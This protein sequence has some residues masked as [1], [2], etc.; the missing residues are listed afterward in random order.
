MIERG[1]Y[2]SFANCGLPYHVGDVIPDESELLLSSPEKF[3]ERF[4][5]DVRV[6]HEVV[7]IDRESRSVRVRAEGEVYEEPYDALVLATGASPFR[8]PIPGLE[9]PGI[10]TL[11]TVPE[12]RQLRAWIDAHEAKRAV[13]IGAGFVG[14]E[15]AENLV[16]RGLAVSVLELTPQVMPP[17]DPEMAQPVAKHLREHGVR[18]VL[19]E[20]LAKV[21]RDDA[22]LRVYTTDDRELAADLVIL[23]MGVRPNSE[24]ARDADLEVGPTGGIVVDEQMRTADPAIWSVGDVVQTQCAVMDRSL[25]LP[26]AGPANRQGRVAA[27]SI[28][29]R[30]VAFRGVQGTSVCG[31][32]DMTVASTGV[33]EKTLRKLGCED[34]H[35][36]YLHPGDHV[37]YYPGASA[38][39]MKLLFD[40]D[41]RVLGAQAVGQAGVEKRIDVI[42]MAIQ[43]G[44]KVY[45]LEEAELCYAPQFGA[46]KDPVN[47]AG[48]IA[49]NELRGDLPQAR[50]RDLDLEKVT[51]IDVREAAE[52]VDGHVDG[53]ISIPLSEL[54]DRLDDVPTGREV[55]LYCKSGKRSYDAT[56]A[57]LQRGYL[58][59]SLSG[60]ID[61]YHQLAS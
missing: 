37:G 34:F 27:D 56:R 14:L 61:S 25:V 5:I 19:G 1:P 3:K 32:F 52:Y 57:L 49:S 46:A 16:G 11:R 10:F 58:V 2:V 36:V 54:R 4:D 59:R 40:D 8:P 33:S 9:L 50:W 22:G 28:C 13:V 38:I 17:L 53:A 18:L 41:G 6:N 24:I 21:E 43:L 23:G 48:M 42:A 47:M 60:G 31:L 44:G 35:T 51:L 20:G 7:A 29:G 39:H 15:V 26:L 55:W 45:D 12:S 30:E